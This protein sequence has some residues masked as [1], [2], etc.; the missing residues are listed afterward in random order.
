M[1]IIYQVNENNENKYNVINNSLDLLISFR[2]DETSVKTDVDNKLG[3]EGHDLLNFE[4]QEERFVKSFS[5]DTFIS[6]LTKETGYSEENILYT[7]NK[8]SLRCDTIKKQTEFEITSEIEYSSGSGL[9]LAEGNKGEEVQR[10]LSI[11]SKKDDICKLE[12]IS[13]NN[14]TSTD[15]PANTITNIGNTND[16]NTGSTPP[17]VRPWLTGLRTLAEGRPAAPYEGE[18]Q[19]RI[20]SKACIIS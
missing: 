2:C 9:L 16:T 10:T 4:L 3:V 14:S 13:D 7:N 1:K 17:T 12:A 8:D 20:V 5:H 19:K 18:K 11:A 6:D 15:T